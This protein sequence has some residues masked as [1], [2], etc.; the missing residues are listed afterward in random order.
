MRAKPVFRLGLKWLGVTIITLLGVL[1]IIRSSSDGGGNGGD[2]GEDG[3]PY[4]ESLATV[5]DVVNQLTDVQYHGDSLAFRLGVG[6]DPYIWT[7]WFTGIGGPCKHYQGLARMDINGTPYFFLTR[8]SVD[9]AA[10]YDIRLYDTHNPG[11]LLIVRMGSRD[12]HGERLR[13][14]RLAMDIGMGDTLPPVTDI[15]VK[16]ILLYGQTDEDGNVWPSV[17]HPAAIQ[18][19]DNVLAI[20]LDAFCTEWEPF[21]PPDPDYLFPYTDVGP[22]DDNCTIQGR[23]FTTSRVLLVD[24]D[25]P[26]NP[27][28]LYEFETPEKAHG[29]AIT[30]DP[31]SGKYLIALNVGTEKL[32][33]YESNTIDLRDPALRMNLIDIWSSIELPVEDR[34]EWK[35]FQSLN[36]VRQSDGALYL[37][38]GDNDN[39]LEPTFLGNDFTWLFK[40]DRSGTELESEFTLLFIR[41]KHIETEGPQMGNFKAGGAAYVSPLGELILYTAHHYSFILNDGVEDV[42]YVAM[43]EF[44]HIDVTHDATLEMADVD[45]NGQLEDSCSGW[46]ELYEAAYGWNGSYRSLIFDFRDRRLDNWGYLPSHEDFNDKTSAARWNLP[47]GQKAW[48]Y[49]ARD[50]GGDRIELTNYG[51]VENMSLPFVVNSIPYPGS[52]N[53]E[54]SSVRFSPIADLGGPYDGEVNA[55]IILDRANPCYKNDDEVTFAWS[56][57]STACS[58]TSDPSVW[59]P[60]IQC[61]ETG[62]H[63]IKLKV[64]DPVNSEFVEKVDTLTIN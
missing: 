26:E 43:G 14:N 54:I 42:S 23:D 3:K 17:M 51:V 31:E 41:K 59:R 27:K 6:T 1:S 56:T 8:S 62:T 29:L 36:F 4:L 63:N 18:G 46:V 7:Y 24:V 39:S 60:T 25:D 22:A 58:I 35:T 55:S 49:N 12:T 16:S 33:F 15:G 38:G 44:R 5:P 53:D 30:R 50:F 32:L 48:L 10:C 47:E 28:P 11:E 9:N 64:T 34:V 61:I 45:G 21:V 57:D 20:P 52:W 37:I 13:F 40:V 2:N 19:I